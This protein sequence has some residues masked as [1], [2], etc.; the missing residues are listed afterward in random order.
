MDLSVI[1]PAFNEAEVIQPTI[2]KIVQFL[3]NKSL[4]YELIVVDDGSTDQTAERVLAL[5]LPGLILLKHQAN[6][7]KGAAVQTGMLA[8]TGG[9]LLFLDADY[10]TAI[11]NLDR[12]LEVLKQSGADIV[13]ASRALPDSVVNVHQIKIKENLGRLGNW[14][15]RFF[16]VK[17]IRDTQ[18]GFK[19]YRR[20]CLSLFRKQKIKKWGFDFEILFL[21][22]KQNYKIVE[23]PVVWQN[24]PDSKV[25][26]VSYAQTLGELFLIKYNDLLNKY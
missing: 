3:E 22:Q 17:G 25:K 8:A 23:L 7:G 9:Y 2:R 20:R 10:S 11:D 16:L 12:F 14:L 6:L 24:Q 13:I 1:L 5:P 19:L 26:L 21:A 15:I 18:C 4:T